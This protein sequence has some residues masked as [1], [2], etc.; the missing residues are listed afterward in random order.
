MIKTIIEI[1]YHYSDND[2]D[3]VYIDTNTIYII[4]IRTDCIYSFEWLNGDQE[5]ILK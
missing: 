4:T 1:K 5:A 2:N 3:Y